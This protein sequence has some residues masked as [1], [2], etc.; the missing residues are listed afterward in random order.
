[1]FYKKLKKLK[2]KG[3]KFY[4]TDSYFLNDEEFKEALKQK[5]LIKVNDKRFLISI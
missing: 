1:M 2:M 3:I 4:R 5:S